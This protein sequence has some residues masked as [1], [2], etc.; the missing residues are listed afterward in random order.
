MGA[1]YDGLGIT[2]VTRRIY[3]SCGLFA[4]A[5]YSTILPVLSAHKLNRKI[6]VMTKTIQ[7]KVIEG[8]DVYF[9]CRYHRGMTK[10][11]GRPPKDPA[12]KK[13]EFL[14]V[15][16]DDAEKQAFNAAADLAGIDLSAWVRE[17]LRLIARRE[18]EKSGQPVPFLGKTSE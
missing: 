16:V 2:L 11:I 14:Q 13:G 9:F 12:K 17:R 5:P 15:R 10:R 18:L 4:L 6:M 8:L 7:V 3:V 1:C